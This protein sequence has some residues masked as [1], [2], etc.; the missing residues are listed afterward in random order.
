MS[1]AHLDAM[2]LLFS[3][4]H[5]SKCHASGNSHL[6]SH[7]V[8]T[9]FLLRSTRYTAAENM[10]A[11]VK[12]RLIVSHHHITLLNY[13]TKIWYNPQPKISENL[14]LHTEFSTQQP[15]N[16]VLT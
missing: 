5:A 16:R 14:S 8:F 4:F 13:F 7:A 11:Y 12:H 3:A 6:Y 9:S 15:H 10:G 1:Q 2:I